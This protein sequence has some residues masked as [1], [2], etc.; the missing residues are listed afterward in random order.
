MGFVADTRIR[1]AGVVGMTGVGMVE[2]TDTRLHEDEEVGRLAAAGC[3]PHIRLEV[4]IGHVEL[5]TTDAGH[6]ADSIDAVVGCTDI[7]LVDQGSEHLEVAARAG[8]VSSV[9]EF[10]QEQR[11]RHLD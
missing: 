10:D 6:T 7:L 5:A 2:G 4:H 3:I 8:P 11:R 1:A 9:M